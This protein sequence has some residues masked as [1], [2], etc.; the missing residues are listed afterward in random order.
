MDTL[1]DGVHLSEIKLYGSFGQQ[2]YPVAAFNPGGQRDNRDEGPENL[3]D[4]NLNS[5]WYDGSYGASSPRRS[6]I[7]IQLDEAQVVGSYELFTAHATPR[8]RDPISWEFGIH[9]KETNTFQKLS[10]VI[11]FLTPYDRSATYGLRFNALGESPPPPPPPLLPAPPNP[12]PAPPSPPDPPNPPPRP[13]DAKF[14]VYEIDFVATRNMPATDGISLGAIAMFGFGRCAIHNA[15]MCTT[16]ENS[17]SDPA[18]LPIQAITNPGGVSPPGQGANALYQYQALGYTTTAKLLAA[19]LDSVQTLHSKWLDTSFDLKS[20]VRITLTASQALSSYV[21]LSA[22]DVP[23]RD[24]VSWDLYGITPGT[25]A[26]VLLD[27]RR[28][29]TPPDGRYSRYPDF[30]L[31]AP[32]PLPPPPAPPAPPAPPPSPPKI[33]PPPPAPP[34]PPKPPMA[35]PAPPAMP[36]HLSWRFDFTEVRLP[37]TAFSGD[38]AIQLGAI[39]LYDANGN[40]LPVKRI[41]NPGGSSSATQQPTNLLTNVSG[42]QA[43]NKWYDGAFASRGASTLIFEL[44]QPAYVHHYEFYTAFDV[45]RRDPKSWSFSKAD[46]ATG[47]VI[48]TMGTVS[49]FE[50]PF[51][52]D[53][54]MGV[55]WSVNPPP[56]PPSLP[57]PAP[58]P[59]PPKPPP[60][61]SPPL[62]PPPPSPPP[63]RPPPPPS[64]PKIIRFI[65]PSPP[66]APPSP[67]PKAVVTGFAQDGPLSGCTIC[68][69]LNGDHTCNS[70]TEATATTGSDGSYSLDI[71]DYSGGAPGVAADLL[72]TPSSTC[73]DIYTGLVQKYSLR[74]RTGSGVIS[75]LTTLPQWLPAGL[76]DASPSPPP[77]PPPPTVSVPASSSRLSQGRRLA[78]DAAIVTLNRRLDLNDT[79]YIETLDLSLYDPYLAIREGRDYCAASGL[80]I[81]N[82][83]TAAIT[84]QAATVMKVLQTTSLQSMADNV[85]AVLAS[86]IVNNGYLGRPSVVPGGFTVDAGYTD[87]ANLWGAIAQ[88]Q[89]IVKAMTNTFNML[90]SKMPSC[91]LRQPWQTEVMNLH[92][93]KR[94]KHCAPPLEWNHDLAAASANFA[95]TCP[96]SPDTHSTGSVNENVLYAAVTA[97]DQVGKIRQ[98]FS[99]WYDA[100]A[101]VATGRYGNVVGPCNGGSGINFTTP[102]TE[103][104]PNGW[105]CLD[106]TAG[107]VRMAEFS[108]LLWRDHTSMGCGSALCSFGQA[109]VCQYTKNGCVGDDCKGNVLGEF[110]ANF[111]SNKTNA[112]PCDTRE[113]PAIV[114]ASQGAWAAQSYVPTLVEELLG[115]ASLTAF[116]ANTGLDNL[117]NVARGAIIPLLDPLPPSPNPPPAPVPPSGV[118]VGGTDAL[119]NANAMANLAWVWIVVLI[120]CLLV[121]LCCC[122][123]CC[124]YR[125]SGGEPLMWTQLQLS[126][127]R[128]GMGIGYIEEQ[129]REQ[130]SADLGIYQQAMSDAIRSYKHTVQGWLHMWSDHRNFIKAGG[131]DAKRTEYGIPYPEKPMKETSEDDEVH[132]PV[133]VGGELPDKPGIDADLDAEFIETPEDRNRRLE[134]IRYYVREKDLPRAYDLGWDGKPF[135]QASFLPSTKSA[136]GASKSSASAASADKQPSSDGADTLSDA[137]VSEKPDDFAPPQ[138]AGAQKP[139]DLA[140]PPTAGE[141]S[142]QPASALHRI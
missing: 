1:Y 54:S 38:N 59:S 109:L 92:N 108:Q 128:K 113:W 32:P 112:G 114:Q 136:G 130:I 2:L 3:I 74:A 6:T 75:P 62:P 104:T 134:W 42:V 55:F 116:Q 16:I 139:D 135:K 81:R 131:L 17:A 95:A 25:N 103:D 49:N 97:T 77:P 43:G 107:K 86:K 125:V 35:P 48:E 84:L 24:P 46:P 20:T 26:R 10:E 12:P 85:A 93:E 89:D 72:L 124:I 96:V 105:E 122:L 29:I 101:E 66:P 15:A 110:E 65:P 21:L 94:A 33:P 7:I 67:P 50:A 40:K 70:E 8:R 28:A 99:M 5:K 132:E 27:S 36:G 63:P 90:E 45:N 83:Q 142:A 22:S 141:P 106:G 14:Q 60:P 69:D 117:N 37:V 79:T 56:P 78:V 30:Y 47:N 140:P 23:R 115:G 121:L 64:V 19:T 71:S 61:P 82:M 11:G 87:I 51:A 133:E 9:R 98:L 52:R 39:F 34:T 127:S 88:K 138:S 73:I 118:S 80:I 100:Q 68:E 41:S 123:P 129:D 18:L 4:G 91:P 53:A 31:F 119:E 57:P 111:M 137:V 58:P 126:H 44:E 102:F 76:I 120:L 13:P